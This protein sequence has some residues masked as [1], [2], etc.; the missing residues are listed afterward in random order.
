MISNQYQ[1]KPIILELMYKF[2]MSHIKM[3]ASL[4]LFMK[5]D[6]VSN[7]TWKTNNTKKSLHEKYDDR[8]YSW[9]ILLSVKVPIQSNIHY[10][11][12]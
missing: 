11:N 3:Q 9:K 8:E 5:S 7:V 6:T 2:N 4:L 1:R 12:E 10:V